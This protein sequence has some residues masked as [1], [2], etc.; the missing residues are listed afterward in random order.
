MVN[1]FRDRLTV[2]PNSPLSKNVGNA[3]G[4]NDQSRLR[5]SR[6]PPTGSNSLFFFIILCGIVVDKDCY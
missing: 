6:D 3:E 5:K 2:K 1:D 4:E